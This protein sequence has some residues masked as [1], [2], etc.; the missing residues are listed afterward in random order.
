MPLLFRRALA[1]LLALTA[2]PALAQTTNTS[3]LQY[4]SLAPSQS[5]L[6][7]TGTGCLQGNGAGTTPFYSTCPGGGSGSVT[8]IAIAVPAWLTVSGSPVTTSGTITIAAATG[9]TAHLVVGTGSSGTVG[10]E[11]LAT[12]DL[13]STAV[14]P[15]S[16][17]STNLTVDA[18][19]RI[20]A[21]ANGTGGGAQLNVANTWTAL[22]TFGTDISIG[23]V[24]ASGATG[25]GNAVFSASPTFTGTAV[26]NNLTVNGTCTG[27]GSS[28]LPASAPFIYTNGS[29]V[30]EL[31]TVGTGLSFAGGTLSNLPTT[32][33]VSSATSITPN[34]ASYN[35]VTQINTTSSGT[36]TINAPTGTPVD[37]QQLILRLQST[38]VQTFSWNSAYSGSPNLPLPTTSSGSSL[39]DWMAFSYNATSSSWT[40]TGANF[41]LLSPSNVTSGGTGL[42]TV[43]AHGALIGEG[44]GAFNIIAPAADSVYQWTTGSIDP[45]A[46]ALLSCSGSTNA[47]TYNISTHAFGCNT[48]TGGSGGAAQDIQIFSTSGTWS[49]PSGSPKTTHIILCGAGGGAGGGA[50]T[51]LGTAESGGGGGGGGNYADSWVPT[52]AL[53]S[54]VTVTIGTGGSGGIALT[55]NGTGN[56]GT[57]GGN[58][59]FGSFLTAYG[60]GYGAGGQSAANSGGG[61]GAGFCG[62][63]GNATGSTSGTAGPCGGAGG[64]TGG[65]AFNQI[66]V[67]GGTGGG[68]GV[69]AAPADPSGISGFGASGGGGGGGLNT[70]SATAGGT[71]GKTFSQGGAA[72]GAAG[73]STGGTGTAAATPSA[74]QCGEGGGG[75]G[76]A[77][78]GVGGTGGA[79][80][81]GG[82]GGGGGTSAGGNSG[83]GGAGGNG[84]AVAITT[85]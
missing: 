42:S 83:A 80:I 15:G 48:I 1:C 34:I 46:G 69:S 13:P 33:V 60:G 49:A 62:V 70:S 84:Y 71:S 43:T 78:A 3:G 66:N 27:C 61:G 72:G 68:I 11:S 52:S 54:T 50:E 12:A 35:F 57:A 73:T 82:G 32:Q 7:P 56:N 4:F 47:L 2:L 76:G 45:I 19:G 65:P 24:T 53:G 18:T 23:G 39:Y 64:G 6:L 77:S 16:Y 5:V 44:T 26:A 31:G 8:S 63:G 74:Y 10:L 36:L 40:I 17:T 21:A 81:Y 41:G 37:G 20:T 22:Q 85:Y 75:G 25:T 29:S 51:T 38:N 9:Q 28:A 55:S 59:T 14:T 58:S 30:A 79:G 67:N